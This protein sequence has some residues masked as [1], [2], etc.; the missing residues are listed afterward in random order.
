PRFPYTTL[1]RSYNSALF[2]DQ[3]N[4]WESGHNNSAS[5]YGWRQGGDYGM[6]GTYGGP[7]APVTGVNVQY[8]TY[9]AEQLVSKF[10]HGGDSVVSASSNDTFLSAY[11]VKQQNG[12][13]ALLV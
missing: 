4:G 11:A 1:F 3:R 2:W 6:I 13:L 12:H 5:L 9:F 7:A 10:A 8:P